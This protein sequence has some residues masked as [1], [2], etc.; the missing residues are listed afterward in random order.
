MQQWQVLSVAVAIGA[1]IGVVPSVATPQPAFRLTPQLQEQIA[2]AARDRAA[3]VQAG[4]PHGAIIHVGIG[5]VDSGVMVDGTFVQLEYLE[6]VGQAG[7]RW[8]EDG[9]ARC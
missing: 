7:V 3:Y 4:Q 2:S 6:C 9:S 8:E 1:T 5:G